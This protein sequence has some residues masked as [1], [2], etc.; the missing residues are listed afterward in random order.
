MKAYCSNCNSLYELKDTPQFKTVSVKYATSLI[1]YTFMTDEECEVDDKAIV[2][3]NGRWNVVTITEV[4]D[5]P[6]PKEKFNY[7]WLVQIIDR[8]NYDQ[9]IQEDGEGY[10]SVESRL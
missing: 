3:T 2:F 4:H 10:P 5:K 1:S 9:H 6:Q 7:T 8:T